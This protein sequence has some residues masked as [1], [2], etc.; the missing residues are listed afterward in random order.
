LNAAR[1]YHVQVADI[2]RSAQSFNPTMY[3]L[4]ARYY[5]LENAAFTEDLEFWIELAEEHGSPVLELGCGT[6][7]VLLPLA[8]RGFAVTGVDNSPEMLARLNEKLLLGRLKAAPV[9][10][11]AD[12]ATFSLDTRFVLALMPFNTL[13][14][15]LTPQAQ[16]VTLTNI[17][18]HVQPGA[19]LALDVINPV[20]A[21]A[22]N[23]Q[24]LTLERTFSDGAHT[25]QQF[26][27]LTLDRAAQLAHITWLY[28]SVGPEGGVR[29]TTVPLT[30][31]YIF[32]GELRLLLERCGFTLTHL[33]GDYDRSPFADSSARMLVIAKAI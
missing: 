12:V 28:D 13:M 31:R 29:R 7:R 25:V 33:Y 16:I 10:V 21:Y 17:R 11:E 6:G 5:D 2:I 15:A 22:A 8:Q 23:E 32:P 20:Q 3:S 1:F 30:L 27:Q 9:I 19:V 24:G 14:H 18:R 4:L 26:S